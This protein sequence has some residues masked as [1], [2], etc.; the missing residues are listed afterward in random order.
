VVKHLGQGSLYKNMGKE[1][2]IGPALYGDFSEW[3]KFQKMYDP[4]VINS[5]EKFIYMAYDKDKISRLLELIKE[6]HYFSF[7]EKII[8]AKVDLSFNNSTVIDMNMFE[9]PFTEELTQKA[10]NAVI[11]HHTTKIKETLD[12]TMEM[13]N[14]RYE[15]ID[16]VF[17]TGGSTLVPVVKEIYSEIFSEEKLVHTDVFSSVGYG[18]AIY[19]SEVWE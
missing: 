1:M 9:K 6:G 15:Q 18:L 7:S 3:H 11:E 10:F 12:E 17:L 4:K 5:I 8:E 14:I 19:A 13:A 16:R 2:E